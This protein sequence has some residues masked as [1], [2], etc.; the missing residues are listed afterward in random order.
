MVLFQ[1]PDGEGEFVEGTPRRARRESTPKRRLRRQR[2]LV[3]FRLRHKDGLSAAE[4]AGI[5][6][7]TE[8]TVRK[9]IRAVEARTA[10]RAG[11]DQAEDRDD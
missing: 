4:I 5:F 1:R 11:D 7:C 2:D 10:C 3:F 6:G 8:P 9:G